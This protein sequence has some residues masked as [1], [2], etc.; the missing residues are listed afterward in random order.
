MAHSG[1]GS[2]NGTDAYLDQQGIMGIS[3]G[4]DDQRMCYNPA[5][6]YQLG[7]YDDKVKTINPLS[8][9]PDEG[10]G[11]SAV[12]VFTMNGVS[13]YEKNDSALIVLRLAQNTT[14]KDYFVGYN[15]KDGINA[16]TPVDGDKITIV[17]K[18]EGLPDEF[19]A[20][21][22]VA[23]LD[24]GEF[25][26]ITNFD[27]TG[28]DVKVSFIGLRDG[29]AT[30]QV[31]DVQEQV[32]EVQ[33]LKTI[34]KTTIKTTK[35]GKAVT[36]QKVTTTVKDTS[37]APHRI[38]FTTDSS[39]ESM[40]WFILEDGGI[41]RAYA[42]SPTYTEQD[43]LY[44]D[45]FCLP[46]DVTY[47]F[48]LKY[49]EGESIGRGNF[50]VYDQ[51]DNIVFSHMSETEL[52]A[53]GVQVRSFVAVENPSFMDSLGSTAGA[54]LERFGTS[55]NKPSKVKPRAIDQPTRMERKKMRRGRRRRRKVPQR[56]SSSSNTEGKRVSTAGKSQS[57]KDDKL[58]PF[59]WSEGQRRLSCQE[60][61]EK[62]KCD[63]IWFKTKKPLWQVC[64]RSCKRC[65][66]LL[67]V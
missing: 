67:F 28:R 52:L 45:Q 57:C 20:S 26:I 30:I 50:T 15:R 44:A 59:I 18:E 55:P 56:K 51:Q 27:E 36:K 16:D 37:C 65:D 19:G 63:V 21:T 53:N 22:K 47:N 25:H 2:G 29:N 17:R 6:S 12:G 58:S 49:G 33:E 66:D 32:A 13:D 40:K 31:A 41:G 42:T 38:E 48:F 39:P 4:K 64:Q 5:K 9:D 46:Y 62:E 3:Y 10:I 1:I 24:P 23:S 34:I 54:S 61:S 11:E 43:T 8:R 35:K 7:W 14:G 60:I